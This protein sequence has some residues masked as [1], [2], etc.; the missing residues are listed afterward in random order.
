MYCY[1]LTNFIFTRIFK[2]TVWI[3]LPL[4]II[5]AV[6]FK[7]AAETMNLNYYRFEQVLEKA[8]IGT[9]FWI[10]YIILLFVFASILIGF[11]MGSKSIYSI[12]SLPVK[13]AKLLFSFT[14]P[15]VINVL[16]LFCLQFV[17]VIL[18]GLWLPRFFPDLSSFEYINNYIL[19]AF[20]RYRPISVLFPISAVQM[21]KTILFLVIP[22]VLV[23][24]S[25]FICFM[26]RYVKL[27]FTAI[28]I[29]CIF[30]ADL[31]YFWM[32][33][34]ILLSCYMLWS[35]NKYIKGRLIV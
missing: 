11:Y 9:I 30:L 25:V 24:Y 10:S 19:L 23:V 31:S 27:I 22:P 34:P 6:L 26:H 4:A 35:S 15:C 5:E 33:V 13:P 28:C 1:K 2:V 18:F 29:I 32:L 14:F 16:I 8:G 3:F 21:L 20:I 17:L 12:I 7:S